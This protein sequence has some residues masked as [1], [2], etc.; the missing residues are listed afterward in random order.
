MLRAP[1]RA[2]SST[3]PSPPTATRLAS[4]PFRYVDSP[5]GP[6]G[7]SGVGATRRAQANG[8]GAR[9]HSDFGASRVGWAGSHPALVGSGNFD[10]IDMR[11]HHDAGHQRAEHRPGRHAH[12]HGRLGQDAR[13]VGAAALNSFSPAS[14][15]RAEVGPRRCDFIRRSARVCDAGLNV[16][17]V[18]SRTHGRRPP[19]ASPPKSLGH[20]AIRGAAIT[21]AVLR[22]RNL[23]QPIE[24]MHPAQV[25]E[26]DARQLHRLLRKAIRESIHVAVPLGRSVKRLAHCLR[27]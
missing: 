7:R 2:T 22:A 19:C 3:S 4:R 10:G 6:R 23:L 27:N 21:P 24:K 8:V 18:P 11:T 1:T 5:V 26:I 16:I 25:V 20:A 15:T 13:G 14:Q 17:S 9:V 12:C